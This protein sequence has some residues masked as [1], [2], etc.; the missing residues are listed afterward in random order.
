VSVTLLKIWIEA[1]GRI[2]RV[3]QS[4]IKEFVLLA[5]KHNPEEQGMSRKETKATLN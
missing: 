3:L 4:S 5:P 1:G 2:W